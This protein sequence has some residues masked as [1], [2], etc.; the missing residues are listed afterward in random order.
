MLRKK[1]RKCTKN[2]WIL[3]VIQCTYIASF[4]LYFCNMVLHCLYNTE[5]T[6]LLK[7]S[8]FK[9][10]YSFFGQ[11]CS[12]SISEVQGYTG[13]HD[14][15]MTN[16]WFSKKTTNTWAICL[17][18]T[19]EETRKTKLTKTPKAWHA[20]TTCTVFPNANFKVNLVHCRFRTCWGHKCDNCF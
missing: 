20:S 17:F 3:A 2:V 7:Y 10:M 14:T 19:D 5:L 1:C 16:K 9:Y 12:F 8:L 4:N 6:W 13:N 15:L 11:I 18:S